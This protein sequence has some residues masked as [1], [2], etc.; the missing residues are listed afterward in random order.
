MPQYSFKTAG[1]MKQMMRLPCNYVH[2]GFYL[3]QSNEILHQ[4]YH[5]L[6]EM[7]DSVVPLMIE[8]GGHDGITKSISLKASI[9]LEMNVLLIE[10]SP[11]NFN[12]L[13]RSRS[14][15]TTVSAAL[16][17]QEFALIAENTANTGETHIGENGKYKVNCTSLDAEIERIQAKIEAERGS[18][19]VELIFLVL[20]VEKHEVEAL[21][22]LTKYTPR[23]AMIETTHLPTADM[24]WILEWAAKKGLRGQPCDAYSIAATDT[25]YNFGVDRTK[26][27][28]SYELLYTARKSLVK[29]SYLT[30][31]VS[32]AYMFYGE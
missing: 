27:K 30:S 31:E 6:L 29:H 15:D 23:K 14:Y 7:D 26:A 8:V 2:D 28:T 4:V 10:A 18:K 32:K 22:G 9:C 5:S 17:N 3:H 21:K 16:C 20:D 12:I 24:V 1:E 19:R 13:K 25:C 11:P